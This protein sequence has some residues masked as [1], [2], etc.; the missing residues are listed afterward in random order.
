M[1]LPVAV[2]DDDEEGGSDAGSWGFVAEEAEGV[3]VDGSEGVRRACDVGSRMRAPMRLMHIRMRPRPRC[4]ALWAGDDSPFAHTFEWAAAA[5]TPP[6]AVPRLVYDPAAGFVPA[7][8]SNGATGGGDG[9]PAEAEESG[10]EGGCGGE[11]DGGVFFPALGCALTASLAHVDT[12]GAPRPLYACVRNGCG[13]DGVFYTQFQRA[14]RLRLTLAL[15]PLAPAGAGPVAPRARA[16][17]ARAVLSVSIVHAGG[18][19]EAVDARCARYAAGAWTLDIAPVATSGAARVVARL[20][21]NAVETRP[22]EV[23]TKPSNWLLVEGGSPVDIKSM[24]LSNG[25]SRVVIRPGP[26]APVVFAE[27]STRSVA[28]AAMVSVARVPG[29]L[30]S[31]ILA[32]G[33]AIGAGACLR[34][35]RFRAAGDRGAPATQHLAAGASEATAPRARARGRGHDAGSDGD[36]GVHIRM[37]GDEAE[38]PFKR[39]RAAAAEEEAVCS[40]GEA[41]LPVVVDAPTSSCCV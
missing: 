30:P 11:R 24:L 28:A 26:G 23:A 13:C 19:V 5:A 14:S 32:L 29:A 10:A 1:M 36:G 18:I 40:E 21:P 6:P 15:A 20:G 2:G 37:G 38:R 4:A 17:L 33:R 12:A 25:A 34:E 7:P 16:A 41:I 27:F 8:L 35:V 3:S 39:A 31:L 9:A 22:I